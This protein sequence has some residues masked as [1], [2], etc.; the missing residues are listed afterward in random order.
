[1][2]LKALRDLTLKSD[3]CQ[4]SVIL[5]P[6]WLSTPWAS[7][8]TSLN[9]AHF[10]PS[11]IIF[12]F[13]DLHAATLESLHL[14]PVVDSL[15]I[16]FPVFINPF[17]S[18]IPLKLHN[19]PVLS[20]VAILQSLASPVALLP[21]SPNPPTPLAPLI[22]I[23]LTLGILEIPGSPIQPNLPDLLLSTPRSKPFVSSTK[24]IERPSLSRRLPT[25]PSYT[26]STPLHDR[27]PSSP[28]P[29]PPWRRGRGH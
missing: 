20:A 8:L 12:G 22:E 5:G 19:A 9:I 21:T 23:E 13:V 3:D 7:S 4:E 2:A 1:M 28:P 6:R 16:S 18:L 11:D 17:L 15:E 29:P 26:S 10:A 25:I 27:T 24:L 14:R